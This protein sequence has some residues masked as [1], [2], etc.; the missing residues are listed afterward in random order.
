[1]TPPLGGAISHG[2]ETARVIKTFQQ[3]SAPPPSTNTQLTQHIELESK[4]IIRFGDLVS[5]KEKKCSSSQ[6][7]THHQHRPTDQQR[8]QWPQEPKPPSYL[9]LTTSPNPEDNSKPIQSF[10]ASAAVNHSC[11]C[12]T[13]KAADPPPLSR[14]HVVWSIRA[15][16]RD[17]CFLSWK[18]RFFFVM[19]ELLR[20][21][22]PEND[23][24]YMTAFSTD[25]QVKASFLPL[26][27][28]Y[29][30]MVH[31]TSFLIPQCV[32]WR[33]KASPVHLKA[34]NTFISS[35]Q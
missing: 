2:Y 10:G 25:F 4:W 31:H 12:Q 21:I 14:G 28:L 32:K 9:G 34:L 16:H 6:A 23:S 17:Q 27:F 22:L 19:S 15:V 18:L 30:S 1:M 7:S 3:C 8:S 33:R 13:G 5:S 20:L 24:N 11:L 29:R 26:S 35:T